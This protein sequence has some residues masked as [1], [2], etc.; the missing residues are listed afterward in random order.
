MKK[1][2]S[3][4]LVIG[5]AVLA[6]FAFSPSNAA[7]AATVESYETAD[8][9][10]SNVSYDVIPEANTAA[11]NETVE[12]FQF[13]IFAA[14]MAAFLSGAILLTVRIIRGPARAGVVE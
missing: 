1:M 2:R 5:L 10:Y 13:S 12:N 8:I 7:S 9:Q 6:F 3:A 4:L 14:I 11:T